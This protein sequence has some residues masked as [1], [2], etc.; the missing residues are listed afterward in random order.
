MPHIGGREGGAVPRVPAGEG[1]PTRSPRADGRAREVEDAAGLCVGELRAHELLRPVL[2]RR[3]VPPDAAVLGVHEHLA[4]RGEARER[5]GDAPPVHVVQHLLEPLRLVVDLQS[6]VQLL[7]AW[8]EPCKDELGGEPVWVELGARPG[9][10]WVVVERDVEQ[11]GFQHLA[12][13]KLEALPKRLRI[14]CIQ[15]E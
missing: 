15:P 9:Q 7:H 4:Q 14:H 10:F 8:W 5:P 11:E 2:D 3:A 1:P 6:E 13:G 12:F